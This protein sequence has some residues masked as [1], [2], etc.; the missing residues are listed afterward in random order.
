VYSFHAFPSCFCK[1]SFKHRSNICSSDISNTH[2]HTHTH[3]PYVYT[4]P[5]IHVPKLQ[6]LAVWETD[7]DCNSEPQLSQCV[8]CHSDKFRL[9]LAVDLYWLLSTHLCCC[10][11]LSA[12]LLML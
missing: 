5:S 10:Q 11:L 2:T 6:V 1:M 7:Q 8:L 4:S 3:T 9:L 12:L